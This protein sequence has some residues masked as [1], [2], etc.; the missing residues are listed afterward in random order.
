MLS[1]HLSP[2]PLH[3]PVTLK[4]YDTWLTRSKKQHCDACKHPYSFTKVYVS[5]TQNDFPSCSYF[6]S[7]SN[8]SSPSCCSA[9]TWRAYFVVGDVAAF[10]IADVPRLLVPHDREEPSTAFNVTLFANLSDPNTSMVSVISS[11]PVWKSLAADVSLGQ[12]IASST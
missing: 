3:I 1:A 5:D 6:A 8:S 11:H 10:W 2:P 7:S 12:I 4:H 9:S